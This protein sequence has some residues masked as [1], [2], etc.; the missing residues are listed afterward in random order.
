VT[1]GRTVRV[2]RDKARNE[3]FNCTNDKRTLIMS[4]FYPATAELNDGKKALYKDL[5]E[6]NVERFI[7]SFASSEEEKQYINNLA[8][9]IYIDAPIINDKNKYPIVIY[10]PGFSCD[11]DSTVFIIEKL[12]EEGY[13]VF[14]R[15]A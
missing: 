13:I 3:I 11:R 7:E 5:Y 9:N 14:I 10:S 6:P 2:L 15:A 1:I 12:V 4:I 8:T